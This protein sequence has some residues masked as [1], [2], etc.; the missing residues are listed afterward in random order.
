MTFY[1]VATTINDGEN[2]NFRDIVLITQFK[3]KAQNL[4]KRLQSGKKIRDL[5]TLMEYD[6]ATWFERNLDD[7]SNWKAEK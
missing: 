7:L 1:V 3:W 4:T 2:D 5:D 6:G